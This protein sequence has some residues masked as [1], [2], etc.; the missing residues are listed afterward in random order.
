VTGDDNM[1]A[2]PL[3]SLGLDTRTTNTLLNNGLQTIGDLVA[4]TEVE[5]WQLPYFGPTTLAQIKAKLSA[6]GLGLRPGPPL[7]KWK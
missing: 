7:P 4:K 3:S 5:I 6:L 1:L 2:A